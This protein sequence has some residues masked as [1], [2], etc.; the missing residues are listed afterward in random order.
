MGHPFYFIQQTMPTA[1]QQLMKTDNRI[2]PE[3]P[4]SIAAADGFGNFSDEVF[5]QSLRIIHWKI[6]PNTES[7]NNVTIPAIKMYKG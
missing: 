7:M 4:V 6:S 1:C 3:L 5:I 2:H